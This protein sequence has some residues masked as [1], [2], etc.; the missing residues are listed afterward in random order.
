MR[1]SDFGV[2]VTFRPEMDHSIMVMI[3]FACMP[4]FCARLEVGPMYGMN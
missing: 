3:C 1:N 2:E 4:L